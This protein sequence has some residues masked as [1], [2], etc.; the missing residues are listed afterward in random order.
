MTDP[1]LPARFSARIARSLPAQAAL[2]VAVCLLVL[3]LRLG[4]SGMSSSEGF[5]A[6][7]AWEALAT[8]DWLV[9]RLFEQPYFRKPPG[10]VWSI[11]AASAIL[12]AN[13]FAARSVS[14]LATTAG[15]FL[16]FGCA[17]RWF[18]RPW[19][20]CA[21]IAFVC[22]PLWWVPSRSAEIEALHNLW[23]IGVLLGMLGAFRRADATRQLTAAAVVGLSSAGM[24]LT[25]GPAAAPAIIGVFA[26]ACI[27][28]RSWRPLRAWG[29]WL[30]LA[31]GTVAFGA[32]ALAVRA[33][34][35][36]L[37]L[38]AVTESG[39]FLWRPGN[40]TDVLILPLVA[41][42]S[43]LPWCI[44]LPFALMRTTP[45][46]TPTLPV[47]EHAR[48]AELTGRTAAWGILIGLVLYTAIGVHNTRYTM[49]VLVVMPIVYAGALRRFARGELGRAHTAGR[50]LFLGRPAIPLIGVCIA[51][52]AYAQWYD[53]WRARR[54]TGKHAGIALAGVLPDGALV[55]GDEMIDTRPEVFWYAQR[56]AQRQG[57]SLRIVWTPGIGQPAH[58]F[59]ADAWIVIRDDD[60]IRVGRQPEWKDV[61][62]HPRFAGVEPAHRSTAHIFSFRVYAPQTEAPAEAAT[63]AP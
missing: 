32:W 51:A 60:N 49:P 3:W 10:I 19:G 59:P 6:I 34:V 57:R 15:A 24:L 40:E 55:V 30:G 31:L 22:T 47:D 2:L 54:H 46:A 53:A 52:I 26:G 9:V 16:I 48:H 29:I 21:G 5:R 35:D 37:G 20:L 8:G 41:L 7:P 12:G 58:Q 1:A 17:T 56:E 38:A 14:A 50:L 27:A 13:E 36:E 45:P 18:G 23:C 62:G 43:T 25:K 42:A 4:N 33:K 28:G 61:A 44:A 63:K 11:G 39:R